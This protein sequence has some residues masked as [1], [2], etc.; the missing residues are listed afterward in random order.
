MFRGRKI[1]LFPKRSFDLNRRQ[2]Y[3]KV[4]EESGSHNRWGKFRVLFELTPITDALRLLK[5]PPYN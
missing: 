1:I 3:R 5:Y 4:S 2:R